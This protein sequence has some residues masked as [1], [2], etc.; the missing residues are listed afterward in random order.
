MKASDP[1][2]DLALVQVDLVE[3]L[4]DLLVSH[5]HHDSRL[6]QV[7]LLLHTQHVVLKTGQCEGHCDVS[8]LM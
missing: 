6:Q 7:R 4:L 3:Q 1:H 2:R 8:E 5:V